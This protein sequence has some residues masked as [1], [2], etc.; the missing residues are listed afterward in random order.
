[1]GILKGKKAVIFGIANDKSIAA[2]IAEALHREGAELGLFYGIP[3]L[4]KRVKPIAEKYNAK[5]CAEADLGIDADVEKAAALTKEVFGEVD[6]V[7]HSVA[8]APR[9]ALKA[10]FSQTTR[11]AFKVA[12]DISCY[13]FVSV[14]QHFSPMMKPGSSFL[15]LTYYGS[16]K[17]VPSYNVMGVAKAALEASVI[18]LA[19]DL[20]STK[21]IRVNAISAGPI[22]TLAASGVGNFNSLLRSFEVIAPSRKLVTQEEVG[23]VA[24]FLSSHLASAITG[25]VMYADSGFNVVSGSR[26]LLNIIEEAHHNSKK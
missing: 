10:P 23:N 20:G 9:E 18:Y 25:E 3:Q 8:Y 4:E 12:L 13:S 17:V 6:I 14:A 15:T 2:G 21:G 19:D 11:D 1:M 24:V 5:I 7:I 16:Q 26:D 22:K